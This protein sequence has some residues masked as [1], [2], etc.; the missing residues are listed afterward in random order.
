MVATGPYVGCNKRPE[1]NDRQTV[2]INRATRLLGNE[3]VHHAQE[4]CSQEETYGVV[5]VPPLHHGVGNT[6]ISRV[7]LERADGQRQVIADVQNADGDYKSTVK[8]VSN[9]NVWHAAFHDSA[10]KHGAI[11]NPHHRDCD[12]DWPF[13]FGI[14]SSGCQAHWQSDDRRDH[15]CRPAPEGEGCK[16]VG[17]QTRLA[18][19]LY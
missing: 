1:M 19:T 18:G 2:G 16:F 13:Q 5:A 14:L 3:V 6:G 12:V 4:A 8:P 7:R 9:I 15:D 10:K 11:S 17:Y